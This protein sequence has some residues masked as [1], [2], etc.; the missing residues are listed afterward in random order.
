MIMSVMLVVAT[1]Q[2]WGKRGMPTTQ[3]SLRSTS[4]RRKLPA[5]CGMSGSR[6]AKTACA[7]AMVEVT[8]VRFM[9]ASTQSGLSRRSTVMKPSS[10]SMSTCTLI[11]MPSGRKGWIGSWQPL[12]SRRPLGSVRIDSRA[13]RSE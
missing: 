13:R 2:L 9:P 8:R 5:L 10:P 1:E 12:F 4:R 6:Q 7:A 11:G 3:F